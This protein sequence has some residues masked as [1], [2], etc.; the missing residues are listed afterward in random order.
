MAT[1]GMTE[2][3][4]VNLCLSAI[5]EERVSTLVAETS[6]EV[7][8]AARYQLNRSKEIVLAHGWPDNTD[9]CVSITPATGGGPYTYTIAGTIIGVRGSGR[10]RH[11]KFTIRSDALFELT[12]T[13]NSASF[14]TQATID[15]DL[16]RNL[17]W[18]ELSP[19]MKH[20]V[21]AHASWILQRRRRGDGNSDAGLFQELVQSAILADSSADGETG[22]RANTFIAS[23]RAAPPAPRERSQ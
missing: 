6:A 2:L 9:T 22:E 12:D 18:D 16:I 10:H 14:V 19:R 20:L 11:R 17:T 21:V 8:G 13:V 15:L 3:E 7:A 5:S 4:A 23:L 1:I